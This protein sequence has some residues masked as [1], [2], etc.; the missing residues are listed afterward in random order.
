MNE[1]MEKAFGTATRALFGRELGGIAD[2]AQW[3]Q[4]RI[5]GGTMVK[6]GLG[7]GAVYLP[8][9][10]LFSRIPK[11]RI[12]SSSGIKEA[13]GASI[14]EPGDDVSFSSLADAV[15]KIAWFVPD[16]S[17]GIN[18]DVTESTMPSN[19]VCMHRCVDV[20]DS[21]RVAFGFA[22]M[23]NESCFGMYRFKGC[24][25]S[26]HC[27]NAYELTSCFEMDHCRGC[28]SSMFC[29]SCENL[30]DSMFCFNAKNLKR[31][32][33]NVEYPPDEY[34]RVKESLLEQISSELEKNKTLKWDIYNVGCA[35]R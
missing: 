9:Y 26:I 24:K 33:G 8:D 27:Y 14:P 12:A 23:E 18:R 21:K 35:G 3:L 13:S 5:P 31:A 2:Y 29:H 7:T 16:Y 34:K 19:S 10:S 1:E 28:T 17:E 20:W 22:G 6:P 15:R 30:S 4:A 25:F 32:I 11:N